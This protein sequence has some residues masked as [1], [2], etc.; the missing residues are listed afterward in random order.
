MELKKPWEEE[1]QGGDG[2]S[3]GSAPA[4]CCVLPLLPLCHVGVL[5]EPLWALLQ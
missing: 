3:S 5:A 2:R 1:E 4:A